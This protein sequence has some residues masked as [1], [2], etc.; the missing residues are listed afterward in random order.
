M[1]L[2]ATLLFL[3]EHYHGS[4]SK[5]ILYGTGIGNGIM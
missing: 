3:L 4:Y 1:L 5:D 2:S